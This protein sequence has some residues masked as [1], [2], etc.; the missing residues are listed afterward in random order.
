MKNK[1]LYSISVVFEGIDQ[2]FFENN[3]NS[4]KYGWF[5]INVDDLRCALGDLE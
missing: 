3:L 4:K 2:L 1:F 5:D